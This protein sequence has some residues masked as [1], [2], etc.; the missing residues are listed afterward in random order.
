[1]RQE[2]PELN[3]QMTSMSQNLV[4]PKLWRNSSRISL[5][6]IDCHLRG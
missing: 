6:E 5:D 2:L 1:M 4:L 3:C